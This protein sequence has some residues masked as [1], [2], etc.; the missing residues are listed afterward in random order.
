MYKEMNANEEC[1]QM[2]QDISCKWRN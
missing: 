1:S 2:F